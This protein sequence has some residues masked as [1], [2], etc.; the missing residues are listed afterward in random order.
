M[1]SMMK[2]KRVGVEESFDSESEESSASGIE[3]QDE[4]LEN[5]ELGSVS[6]SELR[7]LLEKGMEM[8]KADN[9]RLVN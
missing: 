2:V 1:K 3:V 8:L 5:S 4:K 9:E 7:K 6:N